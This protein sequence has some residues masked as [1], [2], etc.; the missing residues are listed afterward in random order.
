MKAAVI[1]LMIAVS[2]TGCFASKPPDNV[3]FVTSHSLQELAGTYNN[4]GESKEPGYF[5]SQSIWP[6]GFARIVAP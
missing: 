1:A 2:L 6:H 3:G 4:R 5:L